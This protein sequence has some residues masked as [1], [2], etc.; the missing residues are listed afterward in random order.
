MLFSLPHDILKQLSY[1][2]CS[3]CLNAL[4]DV[5][6]IDFYFACHAISQRLVAGD[7]RNDVLTDLQNV[8][9]LFHVFIAL[10]Y[11]LRQGHSCLSMNAIAGKTLWTDNEQASNCA[12][13]QFADNKTLTQSIE[14]LLARSAHRRDIIWSSPNLYTARYAHYENIV[15]AY[16]AEQQTRRAA[17]DKQQ[18]GTII[19]RASSLWPSLFAQE[20]TDQALKT[21]DW[22]Q[23]SVANGLVAQSSIISGGAGTGKTYTVARL[24][25]AWLHCQ[26]QRRLLLAAPT[27]KAAQRLNESIAGEFARLL[28]Q[29]TRGQIPALIETLT[30]MIQAKTIHRLLGLGM[31]GIEARFDEN[32]TLECD[33]LVIDE[34]SMIDLAMMAK[35]LRALPKHAKLVLIGDANQLPSVENGGLLKDLVNQSQ[36]REASVSN[37]F[38]GIYTPSHRQILSQL[39]PNLH[40]ENQSS[41][42][43][44]QAIRYDYNHVTF[45]QKSMRSDNQI[46]EL[47]E[48]ILTG[49]PNKVLSCLKKYD[50]GAGNEGEQQ[51]LFPLDNA[52]I[53]WQQDSLS[54][55][56]KLK[57]GVIERIAQ[58]YEAVFES[59]SA[60]DAILALQRYRLLS[61]TKKG[62]LGTEFLNAQIE[63]A[64]RKKFSHI[65]EG[66]VYQGM[67]IM[68][69]QNDYR[70]KL[71]NGDIGVIWTNPEGHLVACFSHATASD[72]IVSFR[73]TSLPAFERVYAMTI[74]KTQGSEFEHVD[75][76]L[77]SVSTA[78]IDGSADTKGLYSAQHLNR[79]LLYTAVTRAKASVGLY[80]SELVLSD[81]VR[82]DSSRYSGL[83]Q[84]LN[85][86][87]SA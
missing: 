1:R 29:H 35:L 61:S 24:L 70:L 82:N 62:R 67:P 81:C 86:L 46:T 6:A 80:A 69:V 63:Q 76:V 51:S 65:D 43:A 40:K 9:Q 36:W 66:G 42:P 77:P 30:P 49:M 44:V 41:P 32:R 73:F 85:S 5:Q 33:F 59:D 27:G 87:V 3:D 71:F 8:T 31:Q 14:G 60:S 53:Q 64:L 47:A 52:N 78:N 23:I 50:S 34:A 15:A 38:S 16:F 17:V 72:G 2:N 84:K 79:E 22:Q 74:H 39:I 11:F 45:L 75:I 21:F 13:F 37:D 54:Q 4:N 83:R 25:L 68:I 19:E 58:R 20:K 7:E 10:S 12:G 57:P 26:D 48:S 55:V 28:T 56:G 18:L